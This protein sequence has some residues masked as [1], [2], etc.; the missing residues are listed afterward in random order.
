[1][2]RLQCM[3]PYLKDFLFTCDCKKEN[4][5]CKSA[6]KRLEIVEYD[7]ANNI[8]QPG[9]DIGCIIRL[10][11]TIAARHN[12]ERSKFKSIRR[13]QYNVKLFSYSRYVTRRHHSNLI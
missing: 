8:S 10:P 6:V 12:I 5:H 7:V 11:M 9:I 3:H 2:S 13:L 4:Y 1:M